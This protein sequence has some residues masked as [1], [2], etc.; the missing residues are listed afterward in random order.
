M[1]YSIIVPT[2]NRQKD[3]A[4]LIDSILKQT[5]LPVEVI[6]IDQSDS[7]DTKKYIESCSNYE[8]T[9]SN[10]INFIYMYQT[11]KNSAAARNKGIDVAKGQVISFL[12]DDVV[13]FRDYYEKVLSYFDNDKRIGGIGGNVIVENKLQGWKW[14]LRKGLLKLFLINN[15]DGKITKS[16]F[17]WPIAEREIDSPMQV[18]M[19]SGCNMNFRKEFLKDDKF[20][21]WFTG[22]SYREDVDISYRISGKTL[23]KMIPEA[24]LYHNYSKSNRMDVKEQ[25]MMEIKNSYYFYKKNMKKTMISDFLFLY[26]LS[27][28]LTISF[29]EYLCNFNEEKYKQLKGFTKGI[30][31]LVTNIP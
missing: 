12:D 26:S 9:K 3:L 21:E 20:D 10:N 16:G 23:L 19:F 11:K 30:I 6:V 13:L 15:F 7:D 14:K 22:Y 18:E 24:K 17:G 29:I 27:G 1:N 4:S 8:L 5:I 31:K 25:K 28:L 2:C